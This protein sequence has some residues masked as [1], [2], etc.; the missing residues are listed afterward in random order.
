MQPCKRSTSAVW[1]FMMDFQQRKSVTIQRHRWCLSMIGFPPRNP[2]HRGNVGVAPKARFQNKK[3]K[4]YIYN[5]YRKQFQN[6]NRTVRKSCL[7]ELWVTDYCSAN[8]NVSVPVVCQSSGWMV[9]QR[10]TTVTCS[11]LNP[12]Y[13]PEDVNR[14]ISL[15]NVQFVNQS[16]AKLE[17]F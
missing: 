7:I 2:V 9:Q 12:Q 13:V 3:K 1:I 4:I 17:Y 5:I 11:L 14:F 10:D 15:R 8:I 16:F 6:G